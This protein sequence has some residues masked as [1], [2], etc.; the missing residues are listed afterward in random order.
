MISLP[1][2]ANP[3]ELVLTP[4]HGRII[5][6]Q[7]FAMAFFLVL[8]YVL[9]QPVFVQNQ[10][11]PKEIFVFWIL[12]FVIACSLS[13]I[14][15]L[16]LPNEGRLTLNAKGLSLYS[17][18]PH[19]ELSCTWEEIQNISVFSIGRSSILFDTYIHMICLD[20]FIEGKVHK[21]Y[22]QPYH[23][24]PTILETVTLLREWK[25]EH[26]PLPEAEG[27]A[28]AYTTERQQLP[29]FPIDKRIASITSRWGCGLFL[30]F[31][32]LFLGLI[33]WGT[34]R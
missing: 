17:N 4:K 19:R 2:A 15:L 32:L 34:S 16:L 25:M 6:T 22:F 23:Y 8:A 29:P 26:A 30:I 27:R 11:S 31:G 9:F 10:A 14:L 3:D 1:K 12:L 28:W 20:V 24:H 18:L 5:R 13:V 7:L 21:K 33:I